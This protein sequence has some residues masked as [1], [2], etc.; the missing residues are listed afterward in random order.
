MKMPLPA[1]LC[2]QSSGRLA[3]P[4]CCS[5][6]HAVLMLAALNASQLC[7]GK[8]TPGA[9]AQPQLVPLNRS[10]NVAIMLT[11]F[12]DMKDPALD[13]RARVLSG[14]G[15]DVDRLSSLL[16]VSCLSCTLPA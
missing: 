2:M 4:P 13:V 14:K 10:N 1:C 8:S 11:Q 6:Q 7:A 16:Q 12:G 5:L 15:L 3:E 9:A